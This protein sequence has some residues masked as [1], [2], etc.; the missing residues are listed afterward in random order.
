[1]RDRLI[2]LMIVDDHEIVRAGLHALFRSVDCVELVAEAATGREAIE[3]ARSVKPDV[4]LLD[5]RLDDESGL[6]VC[7]MLLE[8]DPSM[9]VILLTA[10]ADASAGAEALRAGAVGFLLKRASGRSLVRAVKGSDRTEAFF[11][12][13]LLR[14]IA[15][16]AS[17]TSLRPDEH[18]VADL[19][20]HGL[21]NAEI[22]RR[23]G[24]TPAA[25]KARVSRVLAKLGVDHRTEVPG[26][27]VELAELAGVPASDGLGDATVLR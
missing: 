17:G 25:T 24:L 5:L 7:R 9:R 1:M 22:T 8:D 19:L 15:A 2:R 18:E 12:T 6:D 21:T 10:Y 26:R 20:A 16:S 14:V 4:T 3:M 13:G 27:L 23:L 11:D